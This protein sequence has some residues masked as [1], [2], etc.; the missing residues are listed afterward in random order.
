MAAGWTREGGS[1]GDWQ[2]ISDATKVFAQNH[3]QSSTFRL[4][5]ASRRR[6]LERRHQRHRRA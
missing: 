2:I 5:Y 3:A 6:A 4:A 1:A